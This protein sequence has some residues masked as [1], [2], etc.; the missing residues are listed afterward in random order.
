VQLSVIRQIVLSLC[1]AI[2]VASRVGEGTRFDVYLP[3]A[4]P[5][6]SQPEQ[7]NPEHPRLNRIQLVE[8][9]AR[10][11]VL[12]QRVLESAGFEVLVEKVLS[13]RPDLPILVVSGIG[14]SMSIEELRQRGV[15]RILSKPYQSADLK[16]A[17][18]E[19]IAGAR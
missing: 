3:A 13:A 17:S 1:G 2:D 19:L 18:R 16:A 4:P 7:G 5:T 10:L 8:D 6:F 14:E 12:G 11:A 15:T 9:K